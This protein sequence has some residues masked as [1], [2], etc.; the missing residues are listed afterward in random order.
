MTTTMRMHQP[1]DTSSN[2]SRESDFGLETDPARFGRVPNGDGTT[3]PNYAP[4]PD[5][6][7]FD[8][9]PI[10]AKAEVDASPRPFYGLLPIG[11]KSLKGSAI[12][13][14]PVDSSPYSDH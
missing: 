1:R 7:S 6:T 14:P 13:R 4:V 8:L 11:E 12:I 2:R 3:S 9:E 10:V 5:W